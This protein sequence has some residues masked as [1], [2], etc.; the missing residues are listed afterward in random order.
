MFKWAARF[1]ALALVAT[2]LGLAGIAVGAAATAQVFFVLFLL[3]F[4]GTV[5][6]ALFSTSAPER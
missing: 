2:T 4:V 5:L 6:L 3:V 1:A